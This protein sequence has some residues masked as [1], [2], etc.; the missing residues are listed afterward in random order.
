MMVS[1]VRRVDPISKISGASGPFLSGCSYL[2]D[3]E[4]SDKGWLS[5]ML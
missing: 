3:G 1:I 5:L 4:Q 2:W